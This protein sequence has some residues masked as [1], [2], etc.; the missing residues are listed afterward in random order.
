[1]AEF[2]KSRIPPRPRDSAVLAA[3]ESDL[4]NMN[5]DALPP[6]TDLPFYPK[7]VGIY[8]DGSIRT[9]PML[10]NWAQDYVDERYRQAMYGPMMSQGNPADTLRLSNPASIL[11]YLNALIK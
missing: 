5:L 3:A 7:T 8:P 10:S 6:G 4:A 9:T 11:R 1:M 2:F